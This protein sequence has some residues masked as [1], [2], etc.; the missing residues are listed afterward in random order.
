MMPTDALR[1]DTLVIWAMLFSP[2]GSRELSDAIIEA[3][4]PNL[5]PSAAENSGKGFAE[6]MLARGAA[7]LLGHE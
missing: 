7:A 3:R 2:D 6:E 1:A 4:D 5:A